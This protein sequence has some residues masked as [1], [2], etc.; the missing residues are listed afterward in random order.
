MDFMVTRLGVQ[1]YQFH[2]VQTLQDNDSRSSQQMPYQTLSKGRPGPKV[3][4]LFS[5]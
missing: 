5:C 3:I 4:K 1:I 2:L